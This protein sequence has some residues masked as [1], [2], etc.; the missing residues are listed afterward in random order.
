MKIFYKLF[1]V[2]SKRLKL[3]V[4]LGPDGA[5]KSTLISR[6]IENYNYY[7]TNYYSHLYPKLKKFKNSGKNIYPYSKKPF[8]IFIGDLKIIYM[9]L[10]HVI[11]F[12]SVFLKI[13]NTKSLIWCDRYLY[14]IFADPLRYRIKHTFI[15]YKFLRKFSWQPDIIIILN[16]PLNSILERSKEVSESELINQIKSYNNLKSIFP[17]SFLINS[18]K[19]IDETSKLCINHINQILFE[20]Y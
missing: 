20:K 19:T 9:F 12:L 5:G 1:N 6:L 8:P 2:F 17:K 10:I 14:D 7:G 13:K 11:A 18:D 16:P 15:N 4:I 3:I